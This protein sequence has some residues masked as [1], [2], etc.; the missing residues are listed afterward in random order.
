MQTI[1]ATDL[2]RNFRVMLNRVEFQHEELLI[3]R[4]NFP[5]ARLVPGPA[6]MTAAEAFADLYRTLP[7]D[8]GKTWL[9]DSRLDGTHNDEMRDPWA[10]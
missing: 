1:T 5:V 6:T 2:S 8:A 10:S 9:S 3:M 7:V 4:N